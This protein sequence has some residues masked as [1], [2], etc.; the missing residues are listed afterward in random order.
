LTE[1]GVL[2]IAPSLAAA[3]AACGAAGLALFWPVRRPL[4]APPRDLA[5]DSWEGSL[6]AGQVT[7]RALAVVLVGLAVLAGRLGSD[8]QLENVAPALIVGAGWPGLLVLSATLGPVWRWVDPWDGVARAVTGREE[9]RGVGGDVSLAVVPALAW[10]WYLGV[11]PDTLSPRSVGLAL[12]VYVIV[13][14]GASLAVGRVRWLSRAEVFGIFFGWVARLPRGLLREWDPPRGA[15][16]LLGTLA[17]GLLFGEIRRTELWGS[18][19]VVPGALAWGTLAL[20][21]SAGLGATVLHSLEGWASRRRASGSVAAATVAAVASI[22]V[23]L[24]MARSRLFTSLHLLPTVLVD[25]FGFGWDLFG[26]AA[27]GVEAP[28]TPAR[29]A[30]VQLVVLLAG[31]AAG[32]AVL[33][34]RRPGSRVP[35][36]VALALL[37]GVATATVVLAPGL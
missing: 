7:T 1:Q 9:D 8:Q 25:P 27:R 5:V 26:S 19:N 18:L 13:T 20:I 33:A 11:Y 16:L 2:P 31:H 29:L 17:G 24:A 22:G 35:A 23:A 6:T 32:A 14:V 28:L 3:L 10:T 12:G 37:M 15:A 21:G 34:Q 30:L 4:A 36:T